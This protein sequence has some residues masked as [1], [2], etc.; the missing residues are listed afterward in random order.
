MTEELNQIKLSWSNGTNDEFA[1]N[2]IMLNVILLVLSTPFLFGVYIEFPFGNYLLKIF[3]CVIHLLFVIKEVR[4]LNNIYNNGVA[5][6]S[7]IITPDYFIHDLGDKPFMNKSSDFYFHSRKV[8]KSNILELNSVRYFK[9]SK[10]IVYWLKGKNIQIGKILSD[11]DKLW[12]LTFL[13]NLK[14]P[15]W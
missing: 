6:E 14:N 8:Y 9:G 13:Q 2:L 7:L 15:I 10:Q 12:L 1:Q 4:N 5:E 11:S 3:V